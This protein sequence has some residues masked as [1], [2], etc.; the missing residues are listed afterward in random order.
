MTST[1]EFDEN[2]TIAGRFLARLNPEAG[3]FGGEVAAGLRQTLRRW[4]WAASLLRLPRPPAREGPI[5]KI[6]PR[7]TYANVVATLALFIAVGG[8]SAFAASQLGKNSVGKDQLKPNS[9]TAAKIKPRAVTAGKIA[10]NAISTAKL[11]NL[12]VTGPKVDVGTLGTVPSAAHATSADHAATADHA[13]SADGAASVD[14]QQ[15][16][17]FSVT[18]A[19]NGPGATPLSF[20]GVT[21]T[22]ACN[23]PKLRLEATR[24]GSVA[25]VAQLLGVEVPTTAFSNEQRDFT[26]LLIS[27]GNYGTGTLEADFANGTV[28]TI[29]YAYR[30]DTFSGAPG[31]RFFGKA[32][33]G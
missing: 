9:V 24:T 28:T 25:A 13:T 19:E 21:L 14:G 18:L 1:D 8:A 11:E 15:I 27:A 16:A 3:R 4:P 17:S 5:M 6:R 10:A 31:C 23:A 20:G 30:T 2:T 12:A 7:L 29:D 26:T 33:T 32:T 22:A